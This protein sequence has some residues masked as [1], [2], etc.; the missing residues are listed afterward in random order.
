MLSPVVDGIDDILTPLYPVVDALYSDTE[1]FSNLGLVST[2]DMDGDNQVSPIDLSNWFADFYAGMDQKRG[3]E[4]QAA[5]ESTTEFLGTVKGVMD[6]VRDLEEIS[7]SGDDFT[8]EFFFLSRD[9]GTG[10]GV[11]SGDDYGNFMGEYATSGPH[12]SILLG[13]TSIE[14]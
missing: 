14:K 13:P 5:V 11:G 12:F 3:K 4:L 7:V 6:L 1:I 9:L 10:A 8:I 2:F